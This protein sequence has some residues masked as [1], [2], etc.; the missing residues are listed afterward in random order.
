MTAR[1]GRRALITLVILI[2]AEHTIVAR[3]PEQLNDTIDFETSIGTIAA[4]V[5]SGDVAELELE[6]YLMVEGSVAA[7]IVFDPAPETFQAVVELVSAEWEGLDSIAVD[8]VYVFLQ[9]PGFADRISQRPSAVAGSEVIQINQDLLVI[10][11]FVGTA[12]LADEELGV[13]Q[14]VRLR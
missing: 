10:G 3:T 1:N 4:A 2:L 14:A 13:I 6:R 5:R 12:Q 11:P 7:V 9:G 8:R